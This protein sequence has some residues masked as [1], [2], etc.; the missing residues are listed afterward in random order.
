M[1]LHFANIAKK[2]IARGK[3]PATQGD[4]KIDNLNSLILTF[5]KYILKSVE[6]RSFGETWSQLQQ[7]K[8][9][10]LIVLGL[11]LTFERKIYIHRY[12][13]KKLLLGCEQIT[14]VIVLYHG[15]KFE[16]ICPA[17]QTSKSNWFW[18]TNKISFSQTQTL[19][20][21]WSCL[22][23][24]NLLDESWIKYNLVYHFTCMCWIRLFF[25]SLRIW[26][27]GAE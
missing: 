27:C 14:L 9:S 24:Q 5:S 23:V 7:L 16:L 3:I 10:F 19:F 26:F 6:E 17:R 22:H 15:T 2:V 11:Y 12:N 21:G 1:F 13:M 20:S 25:S 18:C 8:F 4:L